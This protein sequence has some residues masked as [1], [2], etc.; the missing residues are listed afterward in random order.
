MMN[1]ERCIEMSSFFFLTNKLYHTFGNKNKNK[2]LKT[3]ISL[4]TIAQKGAKYSKNHMVF[5][6][7]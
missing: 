5:R 7:C 1:H 3:I 2:K 4:T 6:Q